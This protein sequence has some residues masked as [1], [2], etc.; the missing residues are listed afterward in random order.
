MTT[1]LVLYDNT[2]GDL[3]F[4][5]EDHRRWLVERI[6]EGGFAALDDTEKYH[7]HAYRYAWRRVRLGDREQKYPVD[8]NGDWFDGFFVN[9]A[10]SFYTK[11][12]EL[13][14]PAAE[15]PEPSPEDIAHVE[16]VCAK[17]YANLSAWG[18]R[19]RAAFE[20]KPLDPRDLAVIQAG[21]GITATAQQEE[22]SG[23][24]AA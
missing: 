22:A 4:P 1:E 17:I 5:S 8:P 12:K 16:A 6:N 21:L 7:F 24:V 19:N 20:R 23:E 10:I 11:G 13:P 3:F 15:R 14:K 9:K 18:E 2:A